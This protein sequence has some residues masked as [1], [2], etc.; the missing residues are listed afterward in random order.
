MPR[1]LIADDHPIVRRNVREMLE[2]E[3]WEVCGEA[4]TGR[5]AV[6]MTAALRP[7]IVVLDLSMPETNGIEAA[8]QIHR[9]FPET[10]IVILTMHDVPELALAALS[11]GAHAYVLKSDMGQLIAAVRELLPPRLAVRKR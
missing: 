4:A 9:E 6:R 1:I 2:D 10:E 5:E 11:S 3:R 8:L 7:D